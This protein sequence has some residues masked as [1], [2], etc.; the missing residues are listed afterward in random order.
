M[1]DERDHQ[2]RV[3]A[4]RKVLGQRLGV[5]FPGGHLCVLESGGERIQSGAAA[6]RRQVAVELDAPRDQAAG[7]EARACAEFEDVAAAEM[8]G[9]VLEAGLVAIARRP[10]GSSTRSEGRACAYWFS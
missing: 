5:D 6:I 4:L 10:L 2:D 8:L 7:D 3:E 9:K 1:F